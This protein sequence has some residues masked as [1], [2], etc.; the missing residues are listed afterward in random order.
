MR[1]N[2]IE[3]AL[4]QKQDLL[5]KARLELAEVYQER[6]RALSEIRD[7]RDGKK[8]VSSQ[9]TVLTQIRDLLIA[10][11]NILKDQTKK[12][13]SD[14]ANIFAKQVSYLDSIKSEIDSHELK[15]KEYDSKKLN[16]EEL[17]SK[18]LEIKN[19]IVYAKSELSNVRI[20]SEKT[21]LSLDKRTKAIEKKEKEI[22]E[23]KKEIR[24]A[25]ISLREREKKAE[26]NEKRLNNLKLEIK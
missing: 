2:D 14:F 23:A 26:L 6:D 21:Q 12:N 18:L 13:R 15:Q 10:Q 1:I 7:Q 17:D 5:E 19:E 4:R 11:T 3:E 22:E 9:K 24:D 16:I 20:E 25:Q 8:E